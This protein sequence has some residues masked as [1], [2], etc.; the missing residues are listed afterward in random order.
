MK[1]ILTVTLL[2]VLL[3]NSILYSQ[4]RRTFWQDIGLASRDSV[5]P[6]SFANITMDTTGAQASVE[7]ATTSSFTLGSFAGASYALSD[8]TTYMI[9]SNNIVVVD[10]EGNTLK[11][12]I[13]LPV[14]VVLPSIRVAGSKDNPISLILPLGFTPGVD[15]SAQG[16]G[17]LGISVGLKNVFEEK[18]DFGIAVAIFL[19]SVQ[20]LS[21]G[22]LK[23]FTNQ[24][25]LD[26]SE[27]TTI[28]TTT[29]YSLGLGIYLT[30][31][32]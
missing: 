1:P 2:S 22:Q 23:S 28:G 10:R 11:K 18:F 6:T 31:H 29:D 16:S 21:P 27:S 14:V 20:D 15:G 4:P 17:G 5:S 30:P 32:F 13:A 8:A 12:R 19:R 3:S 24:T 9:N 7:A 26:K 25:A